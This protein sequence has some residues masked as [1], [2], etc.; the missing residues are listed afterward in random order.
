[1]TQINKWVKTGEEVSVRPLIWLPR[2][3]A[4][5]PPTALSLRCPLEHIGM[6]SACVPALHQPPPD[7]KY[8][9][10]LPHPLFSLLSHPLPLVTKPI[11]EPSDLA[12]LAMSRVPRSR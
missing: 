8:L 4:L 12:T 5:S 3:R 9:P 10:L 2:I 11:S 7:L 1:M 6:G